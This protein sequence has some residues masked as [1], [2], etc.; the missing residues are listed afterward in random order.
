MFNIGQLKLAARETLNRNRWLLVLVTLI[1]GALGG[2]TVAA[3]FSTGGGNFPMSSGDTSGGVGVDFD[4]SAWLV[5]VIVLLALITLYTLLMVISIGYTLFIGNVVHVGY[6]AWLLRFYR[7]ET[8]KIGELFAYFKQYKKTVS[9][10]FVQTL[11]IFLWSLLF[12][13][14]GIIKSYAYMMVPHLLH[15]NPDLTANQ[16]LDISERMTMG[17]KG[18]LFLLG[19]SFFGWHLLDI[20]TFG[21]LGIL[22]VNPWQE[23]AYTAAYEDLKWIAIQSGTVKPEEFGPIVVEEVPVEDI[24]VEPATDIPTITE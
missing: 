13:I 7:G 17:Y 3:T 9:V 20:C 12:I 24:P 18:K 16:A 11:R 15:D 2:T 14:P 6:A 19:L 8:P 1:A 10:M 5:I 23:L 21:I 4:P 22:L